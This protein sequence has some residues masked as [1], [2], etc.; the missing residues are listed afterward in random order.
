MGKYFENSSIFLFAWDQVA[1]AFWNRYPN[2]HSSHVLSEDTIHREIRGN[3]LY[4]RK[5]LIKTNR[6]PK[7]GAHFVKTKNVAILE[8]SYVNPVD[9]V[10]TTY[11]RNLGYTRVMSI[12]EK[13]TYRPS[14]TFPDQTIAERKAWIT[15]EIYGFRR[16]IEGFGAK[17][18]RKNCSQAVSG[19][20]YVL[21]NYK[22]IYSYC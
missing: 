1:Q 16:A 7:W 10:I 14:P 17:R 2:P 18:F 19:F 4:T 3:E 15:S 9:K 5:L 6:M 20:N 12:V 21:Q 22:G 13:V 8:E 11:T